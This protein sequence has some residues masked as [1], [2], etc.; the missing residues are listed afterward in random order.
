M[1][2]RKVAGSTPRFLITS[3][4]QYG[5]IS[6]DPTANHSVLFFTFPDI[7]RGRVYYQAFSTDREV[8]EN[9][10]LE[11]RADSVQPARLILPITII[12]TDSEMPEHLEKQKEQ[13]ADEKEETK[14]ETPRLSPIS[15]QLP[16][17]HNNYALQ[18]FLIVVT[19][20]LLLCYQ[21]SLNL[22]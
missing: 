9:L 3:T 12:P 5:R 7:L 15:E 4:P 18:L 1:H 11:V 21:H 6:L 16:V 13:K 17:C 10:E 22:A 2:I 8:T 19:V 14:I 20:S